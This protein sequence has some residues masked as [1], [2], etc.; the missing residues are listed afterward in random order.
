MKWLAM[1]IGGANLKLADG[2]G[3]AE[4]IPFAMWKESKRLEQQIRTSIASAPASDHLAVTMTGELAD[5][6]ET[7]AAGVTFILQAVIGAAD[8]RHTRVY[9]NNGMLVTPQVAQNRPLEVA[10]ANWHALARFCTRFVKQHP[11]L[12]LDIG[13]TTSDIVPLYRGDVVAT[14]RSDTERLKAN[15]LVYTGVERSPVCGLVQS[16]PYQGQPCPV[17]NELFATAQDAYV[18][19]GDLPEDA[20]NRNT[21]DGRVRTKACSRA[22]L[23]RMIGADSDTFNFREAIQAAQAI[24]TAQTHLIAGALTT[25]A[26][27]LPSPPVAVVL[28]GQGDFLARRALSQVSLSLKVLSL[29]QHLGAVAARCAPAHA[30]A[31]LAREAAG[32]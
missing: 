8:G 28:S 24:V 12:V 4:S 6:F 17:M 1:D 30:L 27:R 13:S 11:A 15:E 10:A 5:C 7:K 20:A 14:G 22:R 23:A 21:A 32:G 25:V 18:I 31:V 19:L 3:Y 16:V 9:L 2:A 26:S 29:T